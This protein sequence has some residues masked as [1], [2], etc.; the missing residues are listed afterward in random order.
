M[1]LKQGEEY[2]YYNFKFEEKEVAQI[3]I[4]QMHYLK[5]KKDGKYGFIDKEGNVIV[6]YQYDDATQQ[7]AYGYAGIKK[8]WKMGIRLIIREILYKNQPMI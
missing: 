3:Y 1:E 6:D 8:R 4:H 2:K 7:N 5:S